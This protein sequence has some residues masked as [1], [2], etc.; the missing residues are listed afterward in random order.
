MLVTMSDNSTSNLEWKPRKKI[1]SM[2]AGILINSD[3]TEDF[4]KEKL[5]DIFKKP[6]NTNRKW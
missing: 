2:N 1:D 3:T 5:H 6:E 4:N